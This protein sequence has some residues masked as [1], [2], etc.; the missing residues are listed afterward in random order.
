MLKVALLII[1]MQ[2]GSFT[3]QTPRYD[4]EGLVG[5]LNQLAM[6]FR[7]RNLPVVFIQHDG[8][9]KG[10]FEYHRHCIFNKA[11]PSEIAAFLHYSQ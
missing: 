5:R 8:T 4:T 10:A 11:V 2:K 3:E 1:D 9:W 7:G 6:V